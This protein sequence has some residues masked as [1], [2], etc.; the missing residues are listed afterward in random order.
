MDRLL[1]ELGS[2]VPQHSD[3]TIVHGDYRFDNTIF[4]LVGMPRIEAVIDWELSTLGDPLADLGMALTYWH[5]LGDV[6]RELVPVALGVTAHEG[7][8][9]ADEFAHRYANSTG[10]DLLLLPFYRALGNMKLAVILEGVRARH[11]GGH[12][13]SAGYEAV[14]DPVPALVAAGLKRLHTA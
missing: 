13:V 7:F 3:N 8:G 6:E 11:A 10:R 4:D 9:T 2:L 1:A 12:T 14:G 5:D